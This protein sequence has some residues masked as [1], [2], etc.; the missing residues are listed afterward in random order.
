MIPAL[1]SAMDAIDL[2]LLAGSDITP[3]TRIDAVLAE[4]TPPNAPGRYTIKLWGVSFGDFGSALDAMAWAREA[5][6][7]GLPWKW[8]AVK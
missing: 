5:L 8:E 1:Q 4:P 3:P 2:A 7:L 6:G